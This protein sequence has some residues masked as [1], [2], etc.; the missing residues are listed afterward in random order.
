M[1]CHAKKK[2]KTLLFLPNFSYISPLPRILKERNLDALA[3]V[4]VENS[5]SRAG[6]ANGRASP[7]VA[8]ALSP[9]GSNT[10]TA[11]RSGSGRGGRGG[12]DSDEGSGGGLDDRGGGGGDDGA[13]G[14]GDDGSAGEGGRGGAGGGGLAL[15]DGADGAGDEGR[16]GDG[17][18]GAGDVGVE[19]D[20][21]VVGA[22]EGGAGDTG[23]G[24]VAV[25][26][27]AEVQALGIGLGA[28]GGRAAV[29]GDD[30][31]AEDVV[32]GLE[33]GG[34]LDEPAVAVGTEVVGGPRAG[35]GVVAGTA[36][37][38]PAEGGLVD[39]LA[40]AVAVGEV[41]DDGADVGLGP[42]GGPDDGDLVTGVD[43]GRAAAR[44][45][46]LVAD[47]VGGAEVVG[48]DEAVV[49]LKSRPAD[50]GRGVGLVEVG[51]RVIVLVVDT[52]HDDVG[53]VAVGGN[54]GSTREGGEKGSGLV[55]HGEEMCVLNLTLK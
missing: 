28:V 15:G 27:D 12:G 33:V 4:R 16:A 22:V 34:D 38:E 44:S 55:R 23:G 21:G 13:G 31:V 35:V 8:T 49:L 14:G 43:S 3:V 20:A 45:S 9:L 41:V 7:A 51:C 32:A 40:G 11:G 52:V 37:L 53:D 10:S 2:K 30:L 5:A 29:E 17:V 46:R 47:D 42:L 48:L 26:D 39:G 50:H 18:V 24:V 25:A 19:E 36:D 54:E 1:L 6:S